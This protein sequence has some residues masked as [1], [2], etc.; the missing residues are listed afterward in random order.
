MAICL[1]VSLPGPA[2]AQTTTLTTTTTGVDL[3]LDPAQN[4]SFLITYSTS[5]GNTSGIAVLGNATH[6]WT[7]ANQ[8]SVTGSG[9]AGVYFANGGS[10]TN[11]GTA[12]SI[13]GTYGIAV[14][15][16]DLTIVNDGAIHGTSAD[17][18]YVSY[19]AG[20]VTNAATGVISGTSSGVNFAG[21]LGGTA[22]VT[23]SGH[24][25]GAGAWGVNLDKGMA[26]EREIMIAPASART[27]PAP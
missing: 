22:T 13:S 24:I 6:V 26:R 14:N 10:V 16:G 18:V 3:A 1:G 27:T 25:T 2:F 7:L 4:T 20:S 5:I 15:N 11:T 19:G 21:T 9:G 8:G 12:S 17:G 23:N